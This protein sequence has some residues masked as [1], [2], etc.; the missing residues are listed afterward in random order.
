MKNTQNEDLNV[1][2]EEHPGVKKYKEYIHKYKRMTETEQAWA[3][4]SGAPVYRD[5]LHAQKFGHQIY[6]QEL[7]NG[8]KL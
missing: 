7:V 2:N 3:K 1:Y 6:N 8:G 5:Y 4:L